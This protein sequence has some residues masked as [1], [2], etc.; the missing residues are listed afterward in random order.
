M[1]QSFSLWWM[2]A[3]ILPFL[4]PLFMDTV[5]NIYIILMNFKNKEPTWWFGTGFKTITL[6]NGWSHFNLYIYHVGFKRVVFKKNEGGYVVIKKRVLMNCVC[7][8]DKDPT[9]PAN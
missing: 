1:L 6:P 7:E 5:C 3:V 2:T 9:D 4:T 8:Y